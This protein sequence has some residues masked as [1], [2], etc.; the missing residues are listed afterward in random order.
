MNKEDL[1]SRMEVKVTKLPDG[2]ALGARDLQRWAARRNAGRAGVRASLKERKK[3]A[4]WGK[5]KKLDA[6]DQW[7]AKHLIVVP[8]LKPKKNL[9]HRVI[10]QE[11]SLQIESFA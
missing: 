6:T 3:L 10:K 4:R 2:E 7:L 11:G 1:R 5:P 8:E 9:E